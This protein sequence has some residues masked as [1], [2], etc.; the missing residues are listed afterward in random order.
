M[1]MLTTFV[2]L[3][4]GACTTT[5]TAPVADYGASIPAAWPFALDVTPTSAPAAMV[6]TDA[7]LATDVGVQVM[8]DGGNAVDAAVAT[9]FALAVVYPEAGN[10]GGGGFM[11]ARMADG[12]KSLRSISARRRRS[13]LP[14]TCTST[15]T[16]SSPTGR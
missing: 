9:A 12:S 4:L 2:L 1:R 5:Q 14:A 13:R 8:R 16:A 10:I 11:V 3:A 15:P 7:P 6:A